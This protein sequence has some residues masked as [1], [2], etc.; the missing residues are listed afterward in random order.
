MYSGP[1][2]LYGE[3]LIGTPHVVISPQLFWSDGRA[4]VAVC[5]EIDLVPITELRRQIE[6]GHHFRSAGERWQRLLVADG[7][8]YRPR[9]ADIFPVQVAIFYL[10]RLLVLQSER[11]L[12]NWKRS[13][14]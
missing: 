8:T 13:K 12:Q 2:G 5:T 7:A 10:H 14:K 1:L 11:V 9:E 6:Y 3:R 4:D